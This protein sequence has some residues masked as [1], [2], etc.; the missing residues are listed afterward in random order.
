MH[1]AK[2]SGLKKKNDKGD[3]KQLENFS[4]WRSYCPSPVGA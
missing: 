2:K 3:E 1:Q 4:I